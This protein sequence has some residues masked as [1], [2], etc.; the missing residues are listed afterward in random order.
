MESLKVSPICVADVHILRDRC[1]CNE[2]FG[3]DL[4]FFLPIVSIAV[5]TLRYIELTIQKSRLR[6]FFS[7]VSLKN[8]IVFGHLKP[9]LYASSY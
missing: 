6:H 2:P 9:V 8:L 7:S 3:C 4:G 1:A 5:T